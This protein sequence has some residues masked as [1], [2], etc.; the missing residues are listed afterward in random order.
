MEGGLSDPAKTLGKML[1]A[2]EE[3]SSPNESYSEL[4]CQ[5]QEEKL[6]ARSDFL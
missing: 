6:L 5:S 4:C 2:T 1:S 3:I